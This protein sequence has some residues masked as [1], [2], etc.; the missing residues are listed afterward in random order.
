M[1]IEIAAFLVIFIVA[2]VLFSFE[3]V[4]PDVTALGV[5]LTLVVTGLLPSH[6]AFAGFGS[7]VALMILGLLILTEA[8]VQT[9]VVDATGRY[10]IRRVG[11][12]PARL[13]IILILAP[14]LLSS[15]VSNTASAAFFMPIALGLARRARVS[16]SRLLLPMAF[17]VILASSIT[18]ISTSTNIIVSGLMQQQAIEPL[19]MFELTPVGLPIL[20]IGVAY[21]YFVGRHMVPDRTGVRTPSGRFE[22]DVYISEIVVMDKSPEVGNPLHESAIISQLN[23]SVLRLLR[24]NQEIDP[25]EN[26]RLRPGDH[27]LVEGG[28]GDILR[29]RT[30][31]GLSVVGA[32]QT[33]EEYTEETDIQEKCVAEV[34]LLPGSP[35]I[36]Q[37]IGNLD[38]RNRYGMQILAVNQAGRIRY[39]N[40]DRIALRI[41]DTLLV[42]LPED[43]LN[44]LEQERL[45]RVLDIIDSPLPGERYGLRLRASLIFAGAILVAIFNIFPISVAMLGGALFIFLSGCLSPEQAYRNIEWKTLIIIGSMLAFGRA[46]Q[47][48]GT[49]DYL[50][51]LLVNLPVMNSPRWLLGV[52]FLLAVVLTQPMSNQ[53]AA[54]ILVPIAVQTAHV[55]D[56]NP[57]PFVVMIAVA[58]SC[59]FLTPLEPACVIV[60]GAGQYRFMDFFKVGLPLTVAIFLIAVALVPVFWAV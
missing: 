52:F 54:A 60:Y 53:A 36:N 15:F 49:A 13:Q 22:G 46:M 45:F 7:D 42:Q 40:F 57:R 11:D 28:R 55:L 2:L 48:T 29:I 56:Y 37:D 3:W 14:A 23:L 10:I 26:P 41:G 32:M 27:L 9:G 59:S 20:L 30:A 43:Q 50:A 6:E 34:V 18:V 21:M 25:T 1:T 5:M 58:A 4:S 31:S 38:L 17:A 16:V 33:L 51:N 24:H 39:T 19:G 44:V 12:D 8:L 47:S 35:F